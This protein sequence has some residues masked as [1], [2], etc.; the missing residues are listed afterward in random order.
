MQGLNQ[1]R[2]HSVAVPGIPDKKETKK[3]QRKTENKKQEHIT[4][5]LAS[6]FRKD[7][8]EE[9]RHGLL[10]IPEPG[11][12]M[13]VG[14]TW[15]S[16]VAHMHLSQRRD[17]YI[18]LWLRVTIRRSEKAREQLPSFR[19]PIKHFANKLEEQPLIFTFRGNNGNFKSDPLHEHPWPH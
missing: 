13:E 1:T 5:H 9:P 18:V 10:E 7:K 15:R 6:I 16:Y 14:S 11:T 8:K 3:R 17:S 2:D 19:E 4:L 12:R